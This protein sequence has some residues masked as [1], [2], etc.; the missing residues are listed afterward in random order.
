MRS[1][2]LTSHITLLVWSLLACAACARASQNWDPLA[3]QCCSFER[4]LR[5]AQ[6]AAY[7]P[8]SNT[9]VI[10]GGQIEAQLPQNYTDLNDLW[11]L[12]NANGLGGTPNWVNLIQQ[13]DPASPTPRYGAFTAYDQANN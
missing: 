7:N 3:A 5:N 12:T 11:V 1:R 10:F 9:L 6:S 4:L 2:K 8:A 13:G